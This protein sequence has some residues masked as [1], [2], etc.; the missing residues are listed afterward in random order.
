MPR[1][2]WRVRRCHPGGECRVREGSG[3]VRR[4]D[5]SQGPVGGDPVADGRHGVGSGAGPADVS[6]D[7][8]GFGGCHGQLVPLLGDGGLPQECV[9]GRR[10]GSGRGR[11]RR[12]RRGVRRVPTARLP[13]PCRSP[14]RQRPTAG[15]W[16]LSVTRPGPT[17]ATGVG[18]GVAVAGVVGQGVDRQGV[19]DRSCCWSPGSAGQGALTGPRPAAC[20]ATTPEG[21]PR[22]VSACRSVT[23]RLDR[24]DL[25]AG[26][27]DRDRR[28]A[29]ARG[30]GDS[31]AVAGSGCVRASA[32]V[33]RSA[34]RSSRSASC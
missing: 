18:E 10:R 6:G 28:R 12:E 33:R 15:P 30:V 21:Q 26:G 11:A 14:S 27:V 25:R 7:L 5:A 23:G 29:L 34:S 20:G 31:V 13:C 22:A 24:P 8:S 32:P 3:P 9:A 16:A 2:D 17:A 19:L 4:R 1:A